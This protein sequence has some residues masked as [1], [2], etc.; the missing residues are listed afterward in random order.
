MREKPTETLEQCRIV[1]GPYAS[2][3]SY[4]M[5]GAFRI[6]IGDA[7]L[8]IIASDGKDWEKAGLDG[9]AWEHV[10]VSTAGRCPTWDEMDIVKRLFWRDDE[11]VIQFH[12]PRS[13]HINEHEY[14]LHLW[15]PIGVDIPMPPSVCVGVKRWQ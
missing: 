6:G 14:C 2:N 10:S 4:G 8:S 3:R 12:P 1:T 13:E 5:T 11:C 7:V 9:P 15:R